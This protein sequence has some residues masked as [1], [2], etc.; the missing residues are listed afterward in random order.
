ME[1]T[2]VIL[3][4]ALAEVLRIYFIFLGKM[5]MFDP[6]LSF[7]RWCECERLYEASCRSSRN[8]SARRHYASS[9]WK[10]SGI[11]VYRKDGEG[12]RG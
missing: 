5:S 3:I 7:K 9:Q 4:V 6:Y 12:Y 10:V 1:H 8:L 11:K 2:K